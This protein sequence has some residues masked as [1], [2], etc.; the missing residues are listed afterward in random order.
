M[1]LIPLFH[2]HN[3]TPELLLHR[4][5]Q[6]HLNHYQ[7]NRSVLL[8]VIGWSSEELVPLWSHAHARLGPRVQDE[9]QRRLL[10]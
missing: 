3:W 4:L 2:H 7:L 10:H 9:K 5:V 1:D 6:Q 8:A